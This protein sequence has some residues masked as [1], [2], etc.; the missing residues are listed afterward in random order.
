MV[1]ITSN[2][3]ITTAL[4]DWQTESTNVWYYLYVN[5]INKECPSS[6]RLYNPSADWMLFEFSC[7][8]TLYKY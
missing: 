7:K 8:L 4:S 5:Q 1:L 6:N 3:N 2:I